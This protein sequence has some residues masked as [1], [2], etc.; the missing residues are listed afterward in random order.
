MESCLSALR[1]KVM[2]SQQTHS[3]IAIKWGSLTLLRVQKDKN[4]QRHQT[5]SGPLTNHESDHNPT[6]NGPSSAAS[7]TGLSSNSLVSNPSIH[8]DIADEGNPIPTSPS[9]SK[10]RARRINR[11]DTSSSAVS[12]AVG[13][14]DHIL[15]SYEDA[16]ERFLE[17]HDSY[18]LHLGTDNVRRDQYPKLE[19]QRLVYLDYATCPLYSLYQVEQHMQILLDS[20]GPCSGVFPTADNLPANSK[21]YID[22]T[23]RRLLDIFHVTEEDYTVIFAPGLSSCYRIFGEMHPFQKGDLL[24]IS[25]DAHE[26]VRYA[27]QASSLHGS[28]TEPMPIRNTDMCID[29]NALRKRLKMQ[30]WSGRGHVLLIYPAQSHSSGIRHSLNWIAEAQQ[31]GWKVLLDVATSIPMVNVDLSLYQPEFIVGSF[32]HILGYPSNIGFLL[33]RRN[34]HSIY[35]PKGSA[36]FKIAEAPDKGRHYHVMTEGENWSIHKFAALSFGLEHFETIGLTAIWERV[37]SLLAW[38]VDAFKSLKHKSGQKP[39]VQIYG[40]LDLKY[41]GSML[42]FN[43][44]DSTGDVFPAGLVQGLAKRDDIFLGIVRLGNPELYHLLQQKSHRSDLCDAS[45]ND[46][47]AVRLSLGPVSTFEDVYRLAQFL[48]HFRDEDYAAL[49][50]VGYVEGYTEDP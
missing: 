48:T 1:T 8:A 3:D 43:V 24:L 6:L 25:P 23:S 49:Q 18:F 42:A 7:S 12:S 14:G 44:L 5:T 16:E 35:N 32:H 15:D 36:G 17:E 38:V 26:C 47:R 31:N 37:E 28:K 13:N 33:I 50:A 39:L 2:P 11:S 40:S 45:I 30:S 22:S 20:A 19:L 34:S 29:A 4:N 10:Q 9:S 41:R 46:L 27:V 21:T